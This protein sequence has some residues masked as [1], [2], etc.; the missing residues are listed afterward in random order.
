MRP[1]PRGFTLIELLVVIAIIAVLIALLLPAVQAAREAA[2]RSQ[3]VNNLKQM[4]LAVQNY[5]DTVQALPPAAG[6]WIVS[7]LEVDNNHSMKC[8][9]LPYL[10]QQ[11]AYNA[12][13]QNFKIDDDVNRSNATIY[14]TTINTF[15][16]PSDGNNPNQTFVV[17]PS[18]SAVAIGL[19]SYGNN[20]GLCLTF[21]GNRFDG[22]YY[23]VDGSFGPVVTLASITDGLSNTAIFS[24]WIRGKNTSQNGLNAVYLST[25]T[26]STTAGSPAMTGTLQSTLQTLAA[27]CESATSVAWDHKGMT[28]GHQDMGRGGGY[29]H[30]TPPNTKSCWFAGDT[31]S[32]WNRDLIGASSNHPGGVNVAVLDGSVKFIKNSV[33]LYTWGALATKAGGDVISSDSY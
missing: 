21:N 19:N 32:T 14:V 17:P 12:L 26:F 24:E 2:R 8:R 18:T 7:A 27:R 33:S 5:N 13:N 29:S 28:W 1:H 16:C 3:C 4:A 23:S 10:E 15:L 22:P 20:V 6:N 31:N 30:I 25:L 11:S 9:I